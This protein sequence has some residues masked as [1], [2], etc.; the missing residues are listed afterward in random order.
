MVDEGVLEGF[1]EDYERFKKSLKKVN[2]DRVY[3]QK[4]NETQHT[5]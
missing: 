4:V 1:M 5:P 3:K 2:T